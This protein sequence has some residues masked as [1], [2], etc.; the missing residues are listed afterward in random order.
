MERTRNCC[1]I[2]VLIVLG[3]LPACSLS[4]RDEVA[5]LACPDKHVEAVLI[6]TNGGAITSFGYEIHVVEKGRR[7]GEQVAWLYGALRSANAYGANLKWIGDNELV[8]QYLEARQDTLERAAV[9]VAGRTI[10]VSLRRGVD[11]PTA[12]GGGMLYNLERMRRGNA[13]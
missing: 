4:S 5:R 2:A 1:L 12:P 9:N 13:R 3:S 10:K 11:D 6:E 7:E 8:I